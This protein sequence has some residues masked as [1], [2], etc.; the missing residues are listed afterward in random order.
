M[1]SN[2]LLPDIFF[3]GSLIIIWKLIIGTKKGGVPRSR[4]LNIAWGW[5]K[6]NYG[7]PWHCHVIELHEIYVSHASGMN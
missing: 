1:I 5:Y 6:I 3:L 2:L 4:L 7:A